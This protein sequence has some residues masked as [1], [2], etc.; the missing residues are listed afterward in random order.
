T[1]WSVE[2]CVGGYGKYSTFVDAN[3][4]DLTSVGCD[5]NVACLST[6]ATARWTCDKPTG[7]AAQAQA[8]LVTKTRVERRFLKFKVTGGWGAILFD[9]GLAKY[10]A[11]VRITNQ[12]GVV[13]KCPIAEGRFQ[14]DFLECPSGLAID[15]IIP[16]RTICCDL[17]PPTGT[18]P[19]IQIGDEVKI[20]VIWSTAVIACDDCDYAEF[21]G[22]LCVDNFQFCAACLTPV[23][24][25]VKVT[26]QPVHPDGDWESDRD[27]E[28]ILDLITIN[29]LDEVPLM[30]EFANEEEKNTATEEHT[31]R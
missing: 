15:G 11:L 16:T 7:S 29:I 10:E 2:R 20:E 25:D 13:I 14:S 1:H 9:Q 8:S 17:M 23:P 31:G 22:R 19:G 26:S 3:I 28:T 5:E 6:F 12:N 27:P 18:D 4:V 21:G 30:E 24:A